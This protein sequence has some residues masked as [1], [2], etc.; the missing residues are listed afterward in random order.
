MKHFDASGNTAAPLNCIVCEQ[1]IRDGN[2][3]SRIKVGENRVV[4]CRPRCVEALLDDPERYAWRFHTGPGASNPGTRRI[5]RKEAG[6]FGADS[7][8]RGYHVRFS[9]GDMAAPPLPG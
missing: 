7:G 3:F 5:I 1:E 8:D 6:N 2:W 9:L 4:L